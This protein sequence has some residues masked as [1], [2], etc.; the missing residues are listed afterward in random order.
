MVTVRSR[1][2]LCPT[3]FSWSTRQ[4]RNRRSTS[5]LAAGGLWRG[6]QLA[7]NALSAEAVCHDIHQMGASRGG[8]RRRLR[9]GGCRPHLRAADRMARWPASSTCRYRRPHGARRRSRCR[10]HQPHPSRKR[11]RLV[12]LRH[13][14]HQRMSTKHGGKGGASSISPR[15]PPSSVPGGLFDYPPPKGDRQLTPSA[16]AGLGRRVR[17]NGVR[18]ASSIPTSTAPR[19]SRSCRPHGAEPA[20]PA[21]ARPRKCEGHPLGLSTKLLHHRR[22]HPVTGGRGNGP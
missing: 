4:P 16:G 3:R 15:Q 10:P 9:A 8:A 19:R 12:P 14:R 1:G 11:H 13:R 22:D 21:P 5:R 2:K 7:G 17:V 6:R 20:I 18:P